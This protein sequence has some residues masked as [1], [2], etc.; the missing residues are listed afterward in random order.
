MQA[1][2]T[3]LHTVDRNDTLK[4]VISTN[5]NEV[6][7]RVCEDSW[8]KNILGRGGN[9]HQVDGG[10]QEDAWGLLLVSVSEGPNIWEVWGIV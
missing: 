2:G 8:A 3:L 6:K 1:E 9:Q 7:E 4:G 5:L 10:R